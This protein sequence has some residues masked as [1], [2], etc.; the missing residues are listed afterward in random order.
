MIVVK[1]HPKNMRMVKSSKR[2]KM[3]HRQISQLRRQVLTLM[4]KNNQTIKRPLPHLQL[5]VG[6]KRSMIASKL[7]PRKMKME[8]FSKRRKMMISISRLRKQLLLLI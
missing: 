8:K 1:L 5:E 4:M 6:F 7:N 3:D 2:N